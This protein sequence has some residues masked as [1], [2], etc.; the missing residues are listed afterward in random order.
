ME[1]IVNIIIDFTCDSGQKINKDK[2][3]IMFNPKTPL[4]Q[5]QLFSSML[6]MC[7]VDNLDSYLGLLLL[8]RRK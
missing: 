6:G 5:R 8:I 1:E 3:M 4:I 2:S 7:M